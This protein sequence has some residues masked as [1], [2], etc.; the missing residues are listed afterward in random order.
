MATHW[1]HIVSKETERR[2]SRLKYPLEAISGRLKYRLGQF[3]LAVLYTE[4][5]LL[6]GRV[7]VM[8]RKIA[9]LHVLYEAYLCPPE[10]NARAILS[11]EVIRA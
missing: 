2:N 10:T 7:F 1:L 11:V 5:I 4:Q 6:K 3:E 9:L 8:E